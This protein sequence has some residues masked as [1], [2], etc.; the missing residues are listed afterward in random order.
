MPSIRRRLCAALVA[1]PCALGAASCGDDEQPH[2]DRRGAAVR[3]ARAGQGLPAR[4]HG[5]AQRGRRE[6]PRR[7]RGVL[8]AGRGGRLR[9][10]A[11]CSRTSAPRCEAFVK[12]AQKGFAAP[13][14]PTRRWRASSPACPSLA[15]YDVII[16]AGARQERPG[17]RRRRSRSRRRPAGPS[18]SPGNFNYLIETVGLRHRAEVRRQGRQARPRRR[19]QGRVRRGDARRGLLRHRRARLREDRQ[20]ARRAPPASGS[21]PPQDAFTA[22]VVMTPTMSEYFEAWK[23]SR[24]VAGDKAQEKAFVAASRLQDIADILGG[25]EPST[26]ASQPQIASVDAAQ[27]TQTGGPRPA[28]R[29]RRAPARPGGGR[30]EVQRRRGRDARHRGAD[31]APRRSPGRCRRRPGSWTSSSRASCAVRRAATASRSPPR[32]PCGGG[33]AR[34]GGPRRG[35][36][37][38]PWQAAEAVRGGLFDAQTELILGSTGSRARRGGAAPRARTAAT[39]ARRSA[40]PRP[41]PTPPCAAAAARRRARG[42]R[43]RRPRARRRPRRAAGALFRGTFAVTLAATRRG[44]A[45]TARAWLLVREFRT[46]TRLTRPGRGRARSRCATCRRAASPPAPPRQAVPKDLLD[47]YQAPPARAARRRRRGRR[48]RAGDAA[49]RGLGAGRGLLADPR[50]RATRRTAAGRRATRSA[51]TF[52]ALA[53]AGAHGDDAAYRARARRSTRAWR[54]SPPRR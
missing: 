17:E 21:R 33:A 45:P 41:T 30:Q 12:G 25:L 43:R 16:D 39:C 10:R 22:L 26:A 19:R 6:A 47:A 50:R 14:R 36:E 49:R 13:T 8:R 48:A 2:D 53:A 27:A 24:F 7:R 29:L 46:A 31:A 40:R 44:D 5:A 1:I 28:D 9:L 4:A 35:R 42:G 32:S 11:S 54:A 37:R 3:R 38:A 51:A 18:S 34:R 52:R 23:N 15:D 20:G